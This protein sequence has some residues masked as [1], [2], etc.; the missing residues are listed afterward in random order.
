[1]IHDIISWVSTIATSSKANPSDAI[2]VASSWQNILNTLGTSSIIT[3]LAKITENA[4]TVIE[5]IQKTIHN[6]FPRQAKIKDQEILFTRQTLLKKVWKEVI[7]KLK[8]SRYESKFRIGLQHKTAL[9][10]VIPP[11]ENFSDKKTPRILNYADHPTTVSFLEHDYIKGRCLMLGEHGSGKTD[12]L[13]ETAKQ[14][15]LE[16][17]VFLQKHKTLS[18]NPIPIP[19][20]LSQY[21]YEEQ[22]FEKWLFTQIKNKYGVPK[23]DTKILID[24]NHIFLFLDGLDDL[25]EIDELD[26]IKSSYTKSQRLCIQSINGFLEQNPL[27]KCLICCRSEGNENPES[28]TQIFKYLNGVINLKKPDTLQIQS[29]F[30]NLGKGSLKSVLS[31][32]FTHEEEDITYLPF[33][34]SMLVAAYQDE[35]ID[36]LTMPLCRD[37]II[38]KYIHYQLSK[39]D[40]NSIHRSKKLPTSDKILDYLGWLAKNLSKS[41]DTHKTP[42]CFWIEGLQPSW[43]KP[44]QKKFFRQITILIFSLTGGLVGGF[45]GRLLDSLIGGPIFKLNRGLIGGLIIGL[46]CGLKRGHEKWNTDIK[47]TGKTKFSWTNFRQKLMFWLIGGLF[48]GLFGGLI[49]R[50]TFGQTEGHIGGLI[51]GLVVGLIEGLSA[52]IVKESKRTHHPSPN[53]GIKESIAT[54]ISLGLIGG[55][56]GGVL[57]GLVIVVLFNSTSWLIGGCICGLT[58]GLIVMLTSGLEEVIKHICLRF[59]LFQSGVAPWNF[60]KF[61]QQAENYR[62]ILCVAGHYQFVH[63]YVQEHFKEQYCRQDPDNIAIPSQEQTKEVTQASVR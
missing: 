7:L 23:S 20:D 12:E 10:T 36:S 48:G 14:L 17:I 55:V 6:L 32:N 50:Q 1:M 49:F 27:T 47:V 39:D 25:R 30:H 46:S 26:S 21:S 11:N 38:D 33:F 56:I 62:F 59:V 22:E 63:Y 16:E 2:E 9:L 43:L 54:S 37:E 13:L 8:D 19:L 40:Q 31:K 3:A 58:I 18:D 15:L 61:L 28:N 51:F 42:T 41:K 4:P 45:I 35:D 24:Q 5:G 44:D 53:Q 57:G 60:A 34:L 52:G 29:Y